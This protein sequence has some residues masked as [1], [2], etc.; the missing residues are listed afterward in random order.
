MTPEGK[1][2]I[3]L[4]IAGKIAKTGAH[5][6]LYCRIEIGAVKLR[7]GTNVETEEI[8]PSVLISFRS[9]EVAPLQSRVIVLVHIFHG[10]L[11]SSV[12]T[13]LP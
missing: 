4:A 12:R 13:S 2:Q 10:E 6:H 3:V 1:A 9:I 11:I 5:G 8:A 7:C